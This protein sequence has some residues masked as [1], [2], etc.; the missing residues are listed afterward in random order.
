MAP[1]TSSDGDDS[2]DR[3]RAVWARK[4][5]RLRLDAEPI[6]EQLARYERATWVLTIVCSLMGLMFLLLFGA[7][8]RPDL[9]GLIALVLFG[10]LIAFAWLDQKRLERA[11]RAYLAEE[12]S[13]KTPTADKAS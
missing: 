13:R 8:R 6:E 5:R 2:Q 1:Q 7:F 12:A 3:S 11:A 10:P 9:G 4:L